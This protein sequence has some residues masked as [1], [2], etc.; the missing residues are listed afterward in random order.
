MLMPEGVTRDDGRGDQMARMRTRAAAGMRGRITVVAKL[1]FG[2]WRARPVLEEG[3]V[4][5]DVGREAVYRRGGRAASGLKMMLRRSLCVYI[6]TV[7][8]RRAAM[9]VRW[10]VVHANTG[11]GIRVE[12]RRQ[13]PL[14]AT[15]ITTSVHRD[16][17]EMRGY[18]RFRTPGAA[19]GSV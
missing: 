8:L 5:V 6:A 13:T 18:T 2:T 7:R 17:I 16:G 12:G 10:V 4:L 11:S 3:R 15:D 14:L 1:V 9:M 19:K